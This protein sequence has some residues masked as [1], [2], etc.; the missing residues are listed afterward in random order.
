MIDSGL[1][2]YTEHIKDVFGSQYKRES[3]KTIT[4]VGSDGDLEV[5]EG[6]WDISERRDGGVMAWVTPAEDGLYRLFIGCK[7]KCIVD[8]CEHI[9]DGYTQA[10]EIALNGL[11]NTE[12]VK[13]MGWMFAHCPALT[14]LDLSGMNTSAVETM[15]CMFYDCTSLKSLDVSGFDTEKVRKMYGMFHTC[16]SLTSLDLGGFDTSKT[17]E[18]DGMFDGC[19]SLQYLNVSSFDTVQ[20]NDMCGM[21]SG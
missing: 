13:N 15:H 12:S 9:F 16:E 8:N 3:I 21:F 6:A 14:R 7:G 11:L 20:V 10:E 5:G 18:M 1:Y 19:G 17:E 4:F 2:D